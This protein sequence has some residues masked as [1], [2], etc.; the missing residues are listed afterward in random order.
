MYKW[1]VTTTVYGDGGGVLKKGEEVCARKFPVQNPEI[2]FSPLLLQGYIPTSN[3]N[4]NCKLQ[5]LST[6][7]LNMST[8]LSGL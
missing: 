1:K 2:K 4:F 6:T 3:V 5:C 7:I 8:A